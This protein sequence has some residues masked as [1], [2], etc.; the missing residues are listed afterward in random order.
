MLVGLML[1]SYQCNMLDTSMDLHRSNI[2]PVQEEVVKANLI[3]AKIADAILTRRLVDVSQDVFTLDENQ[4][5]P[6]FAIL[7]SDAEEIGVDYA[8]RLIGR[9]AA[10]TIKDYVKKGNNYA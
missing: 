8:D 4:K 1:L 3:L 5:D 2:S 9:Y 6:G 7:R 10:E